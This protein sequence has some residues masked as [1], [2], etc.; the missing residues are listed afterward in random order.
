MDASKYYEAVEPYIIERRRYYHENP[1]LSDQEGPTR[2]AIHKDLEAMGIT[3]ITDFKTCNGLTAV[4]HG[5]KPGKTI[6]LRADIDALPVQEKT[7]LPFASK[8]PGVCHACGHDTHIAM[9]LGSAKILQEHRDEL[10]G[11]V[12]LIFQPIEERVM[13]AKAMIAEGCLEGVDAIYGNHVW[14]ACE[15]GTV[16]ITTGVRMLYVGTYDIDVEGVMAHGA[17]PNLGKDAILAG[18]AIV[19]AMQQYVSRMN[20]PLDPLVVN[21]GIFQGG[22]RYNIVPNK[23]H[24]EGTL[25][26][27]KPDNHVEIMTNIIEHTAAAYGCTGSLHYVHN[28]GPVVNDA[29]LVDIAQKAQTR[30]FGADTI[31]HPD[32]N[33]ASDDFACYGEHVPAIYTFLGVKDEA[34]GYVHGVHTEEFDVPEDVLKRG[35]ALQ[36]QFCADWLEANA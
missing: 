33:L 18:S 12:K 30:L 7:G 27:S 24:M 3:D 26:A 28:V 14:P 29:A 10:C 23:V 21:I 8:T 2:D 1:T 35:T 16:D 13:G 6:A 22:P 4:I 11:N 19:M 15:K 25:R 5:G 17:Y 36:V 34:N 9:L 32:I 31:V 20:F